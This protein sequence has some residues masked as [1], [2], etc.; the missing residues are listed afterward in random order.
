MERSPGDILRSENVSV[1]LVVPLVAVEKNQHVKSVRLV[2][3]LV[4]HTGL[5]NCCVAAASPA[6]NVLQQR[7]IRYIFAAIGGVGLMFV[8]CKSMSW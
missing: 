3:C 6:G 8:D 4:S 2:C 5:Y 7:D 1:Q